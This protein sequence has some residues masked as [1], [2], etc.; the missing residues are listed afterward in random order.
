MDIRRTGGFAVRCGH[1]QA[2]RGVNVVE[3]TIVVVLFAVAG[4][5]LVLGLVKQGRG[6]FSPGRKLDST[7]LSDYAKYLHLSLNDRASAKR[8]LNSLRMEQG[9]DVLQWL[10]RREVMKTEHAKKLAGASGREASAEQWMD[11][12]TRIDTR[13]A[14]IYTCPNEGSEFLRKALSKDVKDGVFMC[15]NQHLAYK[16][17]D[18]GM[19]VLPCGTIRAVL[20]RFVDI[21]DIFEESQRAKAVPED[22][23]LSFY[24][25]Y[26]FDGIARE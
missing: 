12:T 7:A 21:E 8:E 13:T 14:C 18:D 25:K 16:Y 1:R 5:L 20:V 10:V 4:G 22:G 24:G 26:P 3:V 9:S 17:P 15:Y 2:R 11:A 19:V 23:D 6:S